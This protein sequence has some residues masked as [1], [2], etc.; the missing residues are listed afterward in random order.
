[1]GRCEQS[2][3]KGA[4]PATAR[5]RPKTFAQLSR[6]DWSLEANPV[7]Q[8]PPGNMKTKANFVIRLHHPA[9]LSIPSEFSV[10]REVSGISMTNEW[11]LV[12]PP[13]SLLR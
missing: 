12:V 5:S 4:T 11:I 6:N 2:L 8:L 9:T 10:S 1:L 13:Q 3:Q 7:F